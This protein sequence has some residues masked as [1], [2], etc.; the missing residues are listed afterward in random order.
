M[1]S[2]KPVIRVQPIIAARVLKGAFAAL[3]VDGTH[4]E[5]TGANG[6]TM[7]INRRK[8]HFTLSKYQPGTEQR[9][10]PATYPVTDIDRAV[11]SALAGEYL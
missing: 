7:R 10:N 5:V 9:G 8:S 1:R 11:E 3:P 4:M 6:T 2:R